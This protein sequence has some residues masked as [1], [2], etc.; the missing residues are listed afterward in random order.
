MPTRRRAR[1]SRGRPRWRSR[2]ATASPTRG[3][4]PEAKATAEALG[5]KV[6][7]SVSSKTDY[8]VAG[9]GAGSKLKN[10][11]NLGV[12]VLTD[13]AG[14]QIVGMLPVADFDKLTRTASMPI[15]N[16]LSKFD[17]SMHRELQDAKKADPQHKGENP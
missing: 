13:G 12:A 11:A 17:Y 3:P 10:A 7:A 8:V 2:S 15:T 4:G 14:F 1:L 5:A 16:K 9:P 6:A